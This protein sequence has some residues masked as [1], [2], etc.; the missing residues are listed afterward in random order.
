MDLATVHHALDGPGRDLPAGGKIR[1]RQ[2]ALRHIVIRRA[3][4]DGRLRGAAARGAGRDTASGLPLA[5]TVVNASNAAA[6]AS[7]RA[8]S[9]SPFRGAAGTA[10]VGPARDPEDSSRGLDKTGNELRTG[11]L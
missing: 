7:R 11:S 8:S 3:G 5:L 9:R 1:E 6:R 10:P 2:Q 4:H